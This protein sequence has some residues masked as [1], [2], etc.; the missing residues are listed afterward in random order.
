MFICRQTVPDLPRLN[1][2]EPRASKFNIFNTVIGLSHLCC[3]NLM[4]KM[5]FLNNPSVILLTQ[6]H[7][8]SEYCGILNTH[9]HRLY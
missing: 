2:L 9:H 5:Y 3:H 6:L 1:R 4:Y 8:I 7:S